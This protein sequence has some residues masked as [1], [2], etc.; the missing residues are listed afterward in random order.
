[1]AT[2]TSARRL[3]RVLMLQHG[4]VLVS[5]IKDSNCDT[6]KKAAE[7]FR[8]TVTEGSCEHIKEG[9]SDTG[10][11]IGGLDFT[12]QASVALAPMA[13]VTD[14]AYRL[15]V[16]EMGCALV[17]TEMISD[18]ALIYGNE[19]TVSM[20][21]ISDMERPIAVQLFG[22][23]PK[24]MAQAAG[25]VQKLAAPEIIDINMGCPTLKIVKNGEGAALM[26]NVPLAR[27]I[28][29]SV[30]SAV[31]VPVT[32]KMRMGWNLK[33]I[34]AVELA[35]AVE[36]AGAS[37]VTVHGRTRDQFYSGEADWN[38]IKKVKEAV[39]IPVIGNGDIRSPHDAKRM[40][41]ET[42]CDGVMIGRAALG[43]PWLIRDIVAL[44][45]TG[46]ELPPPTYEERVTLALKHLDMLIRLVGEK[47]AVLK[48][49][50]H[51]AWYVRGI[52]GASAARVRINAAKTRD[53]MAD[54][55]KVA[56]SYDLC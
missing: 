44:L 49:R 56:F 13:G 37:L 31:S 27:D 23:D 7:D 1:M 4:K 6:G 22:S 10:I 34:N 21:R 46:I 40:L 45:S 3:P 53:E 9:D 52:P 12:G 16:K 54:A 5:V 33:L 28:V 2:H 43:N 35:E 41:V 24:I 15:I 50:K 26:R 32:V 42:S 29:K 48:M 14:Q 20:L 39:S 47:G 38:I 19:K 30:V 55:L 36:A 51:A 25:L 17:Y 18:K 11:S 8:V